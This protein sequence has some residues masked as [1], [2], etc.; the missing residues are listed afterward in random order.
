[1]HRSSV[2]RSGRARLPKVLVAVGAALTLTFV[3][4]G[5][6]GADQKV[7]VKNSGTAIANSG[8]NL[9]AGNLS[10]NKAK[11]NQTAKAKGKKGDKVAINIGEASNDSDGSADI[12][13]GDADASNE[14][15]T[16]VLQVDD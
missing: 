12:D 3:T 5:A 6:A 10:D 8:F 7:K 13:T 14:N 15:N 11:N 16:F 9:A 2:S 1:M 4:A